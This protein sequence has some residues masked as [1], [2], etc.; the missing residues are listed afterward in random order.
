M[1]SIKYIL[2]VADV[3]GGSKASKHTFQGPWKIGLLNIQRPDEA[4][5]MRIY[6]IQFKYNPLEWY[7]CR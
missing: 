2:S 5:T 6:F 4:A 3:S 1:N 7:F